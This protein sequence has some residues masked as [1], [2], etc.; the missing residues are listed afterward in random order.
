MDRAAAQEGHRCN[1]AHAQR[2]PPHRAQRQGDA[3]QGQ[4]ADGVAGVGTEGERQ[5][6]RAAYGGPRAVL[7]V[8]CHNEGQADTAPQDARDRARGAGQHQERR[9][10]PPHTRPTAGRRARG[11]RAAHAQRGRRAG[12]LPGLGGCEGAGTAA[13]S[14]RRVPRYPTQGGDGA[15]LLVHPGGHR[16]CRFPADGGVVHR[17][18]AIHPDSGTARRARRG[19]AGRVEREQADEPPAAGRRR[20]RQDGGR[21]GD[22]A[23]RRRGRLSGRDDGPD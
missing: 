8:G 3:L 4:E 13:A 1:G 20:L 10:Q 16:P 2:R 18:A 9:R 11:R 21:G 14:F 19:D 5:R 7:P 22:A 15:Q 17:V 12:A 23:R 6:L